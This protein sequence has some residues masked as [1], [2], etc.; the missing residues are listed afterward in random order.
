MS[1]RFTGIASGL[2]TD[3]MVQQLVKV[4]RMKIDRVVKQRTRLEWTQE[5]WQ[6]MNQKLYDFHRTSLFDMRSRSTFNQK[7]VISSNEAV[8]T[9]TGN[10]NAVDGMHALEVKSLAKAAYL[11]S[12]EIKA[13]DGEDVTGSTTLGELFENPDDLNAFMLGT[14]DN[15]TEINSE[16]TIN[17]LINVLK[18]ENS[19]LNINF[20]ATFGRIFMSTKET[21]EENQ[22]EI[23]ELI[24]NQELL[25]KLGLGVEFDSDDDST[26]GG[27]TYTEASSAQIVY[28]GVELN[29]ES[30]TFNVNGLTINALSVGDT[31]ISVSH[32]TE[33]IYEA[34]KGFVMTYN[35]L[36]TDMNA[37][38]NADSS[39]GY[40]P[41]T[42]EEK[43]AMTEDEIEQWEGRIK[44][45]LLRRDDALSGLSESMRRILGGSLTGLG[46]DSDE[47]VFNT[48]SQLGIVTGDYRERGILHIEGDSEV[49]NNGGGENKLKRAIEED[50]D[51]VAKLFNELTSE[52]YSDMSQ[53]MKRT[54]G[55]SSALTFYN[56][57]VMED[58]IKEYDDEIAILEERLI[59]TEDRYYAQFAAMEKAMQEANSTMDWLMQQLGGM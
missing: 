21:G 27:F 39:R 54:T 35:E 33:G 3:N 17:E 51:A 59:R 15:E 23:D 28:N 41:L 37:K 10:T 45:S 55:L 5:I 4:E 6:D 42:S 38:I 47:V 8:A 29:S 52:L 22:I 49:G 57:Q 58:R 24:S 48:L 13:N 25:D 7:N 18:K 44:D 1:I 36:I 50:P 32:D 19:D 30:N 43:Q 12:G 20:D 34:V 53:K 16:T 14:G 9:V 2:D 40:D 31:S 46:H 11:T 56:D 26:V